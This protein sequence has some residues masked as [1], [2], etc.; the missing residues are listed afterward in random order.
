M[1]I[2]ARS[3]LR[4]RDVCPRSSRLEGKIRENISAKDDDRRLPRALRSPGCAAIV[5]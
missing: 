3:G 1:A 4:E 5:W 2:G